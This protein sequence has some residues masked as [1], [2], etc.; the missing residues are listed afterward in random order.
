MKYNK[1][2][3]IQTASKLTDSNLNQKLLDISQSLK[4]ILDELYNKHN[5]KLSKKTEKSIE[6]SLK[7]LKEGKSIRYKNITALDKVLD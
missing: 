5:H 1:T 2:T 7:E 6:Q 4:E 3:E